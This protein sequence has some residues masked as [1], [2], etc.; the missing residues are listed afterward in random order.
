MKRFVSLFYIA[1]VAIFSSANQ[2][3]LQPVQGVKLTQIEEE[4]NIATNY[5]STT[6]GS[7]VESGYYFESDTSSAWNKT[8]WGAK[9]TI[10]AGTGTS[11]T[12]QNFYSQGKSLQATMT[13]E[14]S[15]AIKPGVVATVNGWNAYLYKA[16]KTSTGWTYSSTAN[17]DGVVSENG[18]LVIGSCVILDPV[19]NLLYEV[20][21]GSRLYK[22]NAVAEREDIDGEQSAVWLLVRQTGTYSAKILNFTDMLDE[23]EVRLPGGNE[24]EIDPQKAYSYSILGE[25]FVYPTDFENIP[26]TQVGSFKQTMNAEGPLVGLVDGSTIK[27]GNWGV[28]LQ[29]T[30]PKVMLEG[31][32]STKLTLSKNV[33]S[34]PEKKQFTLN[35]EGTELNPYSISTAE[36]V[37][38]L[39]QLVNSGNTL[40]GKV[41][42]V[43]EDLDLVNMLPLFRPIGNEKYPFEGVFDGNNHRVTHFNYATY[44]LKNTGFFGYVGSKGV[45][46]NLDIDAQIYTKGM[47]A[48]LIAGTCDGEVLNCKAGGRII[49]GNTRT[50]GIV[51]V[52]KNGG[53]VK[54]CEVQYE[55]I[56]AGASATGGIV[57]YLKGGTV[58]DCKVKAYVTHGDN[59]I[60][61]DNLGYGGIVGSAYGTDETPSSIIN[62]YFAGQLF[63]KSERAVLGGI[64]GYAEGASVSTCMS[65]G[66]INSNASKMQAMNSSG[67]SILKDVGATGGLVGR[68]INS[69]FSNSL[70]M[71]SIFNA[72]NNGQLG[73]IV[74]DV[75]DSDHT[76]SFETCFSAAQIFNNEENSNRSVYGKCNR[77]NAPFLHTY[78]D[79]QVTGLYGA[80]GGVETAELISGE[81]LTGFSSDVWNFQKGLYPTLKVFESELESKF[82]ALPVVFGKGETSR[83]I[84]SDFA[85][86]STEVL[87]WQVVNGTNNGTEGSTIKIV[88]DS[89][90]LTG[91]NGV[92]TL[93]LQLPDSYVTRY[94]E[95]KVIGT[96]EFEGEGTADNPYR[97]RTS[98]DLVALA[99]QVNEIK[100]SYDGKHFL[101][102]ND[103]DMRDVAFDGIGKRSGSGITLVERKFGGIFDGGGYAIHN[104][105]MKG[106]VLSGTSVDT[107]NSKENV[108]MFV[109][110]NSASEIKNLTISNDCAF[111]GYRFVASVACYTNGKIS[112][113]R[114][115]AP[116]VASSVCAGGIVASC[117]GGTI[118]ECYNAGDVSIGSQ[119]GGGIVAVTNNQSGVSLCQNDGNVGL[120]PAYGKSATN[121]GGIIG[122]ASGLVEDCVNNGSI[123]GV[124]IGG[125]CGSG[126]SGVEI[127]R[128]LNN[129][130]IS[131]ITVNQSS[132]FGAII[133]ATTTGEQKMSDCYYDRQIC[134]I[135][136]AKL[137]KDMCKGL[138]TATLVSG[139]SIP[140]LNKDVFHYAPNSYPVLKAFCQ[141]NATQTLRTLWLQLDSVD[142]AQTIRHNAT[143][144]LP[145]GAVWK[146]ES[147]AEHFAISNNELQ[148]SVPSD[149]V[150][151]AIVSVEANGEKKVISLRSVPV[152]FEGDGTE[153]NPFLI[154][155]TADV[156]KLREAVNSMLI[157]FAGSHFKVTQDLD[158]ADYGNFGP[159]A[160]FDGNSAARCVFDGDFNGDGHT[161]SN[162]TAEGTSKST[163]FGLFGMLGQNGCIRNLTIKDSRFAA[164]SYVAPFAGYVTGK[165]K[166]CVNQGTAVATLNSSGE[167]Y[168]AS[169]G[170]VVAYVDGFG[171]IDSC[172]NRG[173]VQGCVW[174]A[175]V[176]SEAG[177]NAVIN[178]CI[179]YQ[180]IDSEKGNVMAGVVARAGGTV[181][182]CAN[183]GSIISK[184]TSSTISGVVG[185]F[186]RSGK[187]TH[188]A[189]YGDVT[190]LSASMVGGVIGYSGTLPVAFDSCENYGKVKGSMEVGGIV[191]RF[192]R[193]CTLTNCIN[194]A[195]VEGNADKLGGIA[196][197][198]DAQ[199]GHANKIE[200]CR[201][202]GP[203]SGSAKTMGG[204]AG[205]ITTKFSSVTGCY[206]AGNIDAS[207]ALLAGGIAGSASCPIST[208]FNGGDITASDSTLVGGLVG[209]TD[210]EVADCYQLGDILA[211]GN[212]AALIGEAA[213]GASLQRCFNAG[214][215]KAQGNGV[216]TALKGVEGF[217]AT[218]IYFDKEASE[219]EA[220]GIASAQGVGVR[221]LCG[222]Q[223]SEYFTLGDAAY[224]RLTCWD[225]D[226]IANF[227][228]A[229]A[230]PAE[231]ESLKKVVSPLVLA[232]F[233]GTW[234]EAAEGLWI[235]DGKAY[236]T[237]IGATTLTKKCG[238]FSKTLNVNV[239]EL[240]HVD[241]AL[242]SKYAVKTTY[243]HINGQLI[244]EQQPDTHGIYIEETQY[245][246]KTTSA[247]KIVR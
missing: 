181:S 101:M 115:Y 241:N 95:T 23:C 213:E 158:F 208:S 236:G 73:S 244:G 193:D 239:A 70:S 172:V 92:D 2:K 147:G 214:C 27:F 188:C 79:V 39:S 145:E 3:E 30:D 60:T 153:E 160:Q 85:L 17:I 6:A 206:N 116:V 88:G 76:S 231:S 148:V 182:G 47:N 122:N 154:S 74:G 90:K 15:F 18:D 121:V 143:L 230:L 93:A 204:V 132:L 238:N 67:Q 152:L 219:I 119:M 89:V 209:W 37:L 226:T 68:T 33:L 225:A 111:E 123:S 156:T 228:A 107:R 34:F 149:N 173:H 229:T 220:E 210:A 78:Y 227:F 53:T 211:E 163:R 180:D 232:S 91:V 207:K 161:F 146:V 175:G 191:G 192:Y 26:I 195:A 139:D 131:P 212:A 83:T 130:V 178:D 155:S 8:F 50:G 32:K 176:V 135:N 69:R 205:Y 171:S 186:I 57:G 65:C 142:N 234:W 28:L 80:S 218:H 103:I 110:C 58:K 44:D 98:N 63:C 133:G 159:I 94:L 150:A 198:V 113:C 106:I 194:H 166:A 235:K 168:T 11:F 71:T 141:E 157:D 40:E 202:L 126:L 13:G 217:D 45:V 124:T 9:V 117:E 125:I 174:S 109:T 75:D 12:I 189:N 19:N 77:D 187:M 66:L 129:G 59:V 38:A 42:K 164:G 179:N 185:L 196:G 190:A 183:Y 246:D 128:V 29:Y 51:G 199:N 237:K 100:N 177:Q 134:A 56:V 36:D 102:T 62:C 200:L 140:G 22:S 61:K 82:C 49:T 221:E 48:G 10:S 41:V 105:Q 14:N 224:P 233:S 223:I 222:S 35:G 108:A 5:V 114:N 16:I 245:S 240:S 144:H 201:N 167:A 169:L 4:A 31:Y 216:I 43:V 97:I 99:R 21:E 151:N 81:A 243:Y 184:T 20:L 137:P 7:A 138:L 215:I 87:K 104:L 112:N 165:V 55:G 25:F 247:R 24:I 162:I 197:F 96:N 72:P 118:S 170:G 64:V 86:S 84:K 46:K 52:L 136:T 54:D 242:P 127:H 120:N 1:F 203:I